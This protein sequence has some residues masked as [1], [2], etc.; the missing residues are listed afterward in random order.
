MSIATHSFQLWSWLLLASAGLNVILIG[1]KR[2]A[3]GAFISGIRS[4]FN[5]TVSL[6]ELNWIGDSDSCLGFLLITPTSMLVM[7]SRRFRTMQATGALFVLISG[8][9]SAFAP[10]PH[11][12]FL[13]HTVFYAIGCALIH[14]TS[15][16]IVNEHFPVSHPHHLFATALLSS[17][18][19]GAGIFVP[20]FAF[21]IQSMGCSKAFLIIGLGYFMIF[22]FSLIFFLPSTIP[23]FSVSNRT[24]FCQVIWIK[25][26]WRMLSV[27]LW[28]TDRALATSVVFG[29]LMNLT[30]MARREHGKD[31]VGA[32]TLVALFTVGEAVGYMTSITL[33]FG[34]TRSFFQQRLRFVLLMCTCGMATA[35]CLLHWFQNSYLLIFLAGLNFSPNTTF[36]FAAGEELT[37]LPGPVA[38]QTAYF[39]SALGLMV[40]PLL[41]AYLIEKYSYGSFFLHQGGL[42]WIKAAVILFASFVLSKIVVD[43]E[44]D[45]G[46]VEEEGEGGE[47]RTEEHVLIKRNP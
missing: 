10:N 19:L 26:D 31:L 25:Q 13:T 8:I 14:S 3:F 43:E 17:G 15:S 28:I 32:S 24:C 23:L 36:I 4:E 44:C 11:W 12:L 33:V 22:C 20:I 16:L 34:L 5:S 6:T 45:E 1:G 46:E 21:F 7:R 37:R 47:E 38:Y 27:I 30:D 40:A 9:A 18:S 35:V 29:L 42:L 41:S 39:G 2:R